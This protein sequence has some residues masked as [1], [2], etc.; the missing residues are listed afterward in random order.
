MV[1]LKIDILLLQKFNSDYKN[2]N[3]I[4]HKVLD[5]YE[6]H[7]SHPGNKPKV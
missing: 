7:L 3:T 1:I 5:F 2:P 4:A 6:W